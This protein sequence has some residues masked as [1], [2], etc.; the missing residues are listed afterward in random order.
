MKICIN[1]GKQNNVIKKHQFQ[2]EI[3]IWQILSVEK[4]INFD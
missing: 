4:I 3:A 1:Y 2:Q